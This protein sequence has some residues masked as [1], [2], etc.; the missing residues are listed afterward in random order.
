MSRRQLY[1]MRHAKSSWK[2]PLADLD[3]PLNQRGLDDAPRMGLRLS[4]R[5][6]QVDLLVSSHA[7]RAIR[8]AQLVA[9]S[10]NYPME[11]L[12]VQP[13]LYTEDAATIIQVIQSLDD[14]YHA[15]MLLGHNP[16]FTELANRL[17]HIPIVNVPT[18]GVVHLEM[19][20]AHW[21]HFDASKVEFVDFD[22]PKRLDD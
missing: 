2:Y 7:L 6:T 17:A 10:L 14:R 12:C 18:A 4:R 5:A 11:Q 21:E 15:V 19:E 1:L 3:R 16:V 8:T 9:E 22:Y 13:R 20:L